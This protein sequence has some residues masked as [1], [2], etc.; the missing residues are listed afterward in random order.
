MAKYDGI[1][2]ECTFIDFN[3]L[4]TK[5]AWIPYPGAVELAR[6]V[7]QTH[8]AGVNGI[9][10]GL[11]KLPHYQITT[12]PNGDIAILIGLLLPA[13]QKIRDPASAERRVLAG[14]L[15]P[16]RTAAPMVGNP[17]ERQASPG[18]NWGLIT[19]LHDR[20]SGMPSRFYAMVN[21][22]SGG[23]LES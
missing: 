8:P 1:D 21:G 4:R 2:G 3:Q 15:A 9:L 11:L 12:G 18:G 20:A 6:K 14:V 16:G 23:Y 7:R 5:A 17:L 19:S 13:V 22:Q 10:I